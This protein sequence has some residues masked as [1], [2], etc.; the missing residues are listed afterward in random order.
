MNN[1]IPNKNDIKLY[2]KLLRLTNHQLSE[3]HKNVDRD[4]NKWNKYVFLYKNT[5]FKQT[6]LKLLAQ[7]ATRLSKKEAKLCEKEALDEMMNELKTIEAD[8]GK[9]NA[10]GTPE[11][12]YIRIM[13]H[14][15]LDISGDE[16]PQEKKTYKLKISEC[17]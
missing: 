2:K 10:T 15:L 14:G 16:D 1:P 17:G 5:I 12:D 9:W 3:I 6:I 11:V 7:K 4:A 13:V 8:K